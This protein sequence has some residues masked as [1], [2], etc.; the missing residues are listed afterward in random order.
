MSSIFL[1]FYNNL[2]QFSLKRISDDIKNQEWLL[3]KVPPRFLA[4]L[5][6]ILS[7]TAIFFEL[8]YFPH[9]AVEIITI[10]LISTVIGFVVLSFLKTETDENT[11]V[12][13]FHLLLLT[14]V[15]SSGLI[16]YFIP[17]SIL[18]NASMIGLTIFT[19]ALFLNWE[20]HQQIIVSI[21]YNIIYALAV[22]ITYLHNTFV[23]FLPESLLIVLF[24]S[25]ISIVACTVN[26]KVR[27]LEKERNLEIKKSEFKYRSIIDNSLEG[28][29]QSSIE[30]KWLTINKSFAQILGYSDIKE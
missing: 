10:R 6:V 16:I 27:L 29:F 19:S 4:Y 23:P 18:L 30:G 22:V 3:I 26:F 20:I 25:I 24:L 12:L 8:S 15:I 11:R 28:I 21:Y 5:V 7:L 9:Y 13:L 2:R 1:N 17:A 14:V